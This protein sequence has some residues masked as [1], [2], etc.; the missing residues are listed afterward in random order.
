[1]ETNQINFYD[2]PDHISTLEYDGDSND[3]RLFLKDTISWST[4][5]KRAY[6]KIEKDIRTKKIKG[7]GWVAHAWCDVSGYDY[8]MRERQEDNYAQITVS[9]E[10]EEVD[11]NEIEKI[12][13]A[14]EEMGEHF[15]YLLSF[16]NS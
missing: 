3:R 12:E 15:S 6:Q 7:N 10:R 8:W 13:K 5:G 1:M 2:I 4:E 14:L 11:T 9:F 16:W